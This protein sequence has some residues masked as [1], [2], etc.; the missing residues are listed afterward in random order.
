MNTRERI[1]EKAKALFT[2]RGYDVTPMSLV[3]KEVG[4]TK[5]GLYYYICGKEHLLFLIHEYYLKKDFIPI[6]EKAERI[7]DPEDRLTYFIESY[8]RLLA[9]D[10]APRVLIHEANRLAPEHYR[11]IRQIWKR[12]FDVIRDGISDLAISGKGKKLNKTFAAFAAIGMCSWVF[13]W[14][15]YFRRESAEELSKNF[16]EIFLKGILKH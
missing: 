12:G 14:F 15:D 7:S 10:P 13:Y 5:A 8:T 11:I 3:A 16:A 6:V 4:L 1:Y 9:R 2:D